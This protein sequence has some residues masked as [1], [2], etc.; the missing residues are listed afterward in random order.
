[1]LPD[2]LSLE[3][4]AIVLPLGDGDFRLAVNAALADFY[5]RRAHADLLE[6]VLERRPR[7]RRV[8]RSVICVRRNT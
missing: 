6:V 8:A 4:Y 5:R 1:M 2:D 7:A 3:P